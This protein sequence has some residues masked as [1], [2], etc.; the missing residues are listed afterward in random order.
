MSMTIL[1]MNIEL[2]LLCV[3]FVCILFCFNLR[4][5]RPNIINPLSVIYLM[6]IAGCFFEIAAF[7]ANGKSDL[8]WLNY[9]SNILYLSSIGIS[10]ACML[11][12][13]HGLFPAPIWKS[14][15]Q[16]I[17]MMLPVII[18]LLLLF[19]A[20]KTGLIFYVDDA[21][22]YFRGKTFFL[23]MIPYG[24]L[25][26]ATIYGIY[27]FCKSETTKEKSQYLAISMFAIP[28]FFLG[29]IQLLVT[30]NS[31]DILEFSVAIALLI[32]FVVGQNNRITRDSLTKLPNREVLDTVLLEK[33]RKDHKDSSESLFVMMCDLDKFKEINDTYGHLEGDHALIL[34][35]NVLYEISHKYK[36]TAARFGGDEFVIVLES[37]SKDTPKAVIE[38]INQR[39][40]EV[41]ESEKFTLQMSVG[42][43]FY[44]PSDTI[45]DILKA[46]DRELYRIKNQ[47]K[48]HLLGRA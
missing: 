46:A 32:N 47:K 3:I 38:E 12:Y 2:L 1:S 42:Y 41:S 14:K 39:L 37:D 30:P 25:L 48:K 5:W 34:A 4:Y 20:P 9:L 28:P 45:A 36:A 43:T 31:M 13:C 19:S 16:H 6:T 29:G 35:A 21:G 24:Y 17:L 10:G 18:E 11:C 40:L 26:C 33:M 7:Y 23:Q 27:W 15:K 22:T 44:R 8:I